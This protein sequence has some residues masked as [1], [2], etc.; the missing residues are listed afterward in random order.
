MKV[1]LF[2]MKKL[3]EKKRKKKRKDI[4]KIDYM[5]NAKQLTFAHVL[6]TSFNIL[7]F[8]KICKRSKADYI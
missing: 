2:S 5:C 8:S 4:N 6:S 3:K 7:T 1:Y